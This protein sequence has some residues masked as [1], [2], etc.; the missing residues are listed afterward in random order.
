[1]SHWII[2]VAS[3]KFYV[4]GY[5]LYSAIGNL[6]RG[7]TLKSFDEIKQAVGVVSR[8]RTHVNESHT[9]LR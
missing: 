8:D 2:V 5:V 1:M 4:R 9:Y 6:L 7:S 3:V